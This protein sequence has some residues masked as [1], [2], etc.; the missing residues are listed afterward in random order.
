M[1]KELLE[2]LEAK[3]VLRSK[4]ENAQ[5]MEELNSLKD[6]LNALENKEAL[7]IERSKM[8]QKLAN[9]PAAGNT[10]PVPGKGMEEKPDL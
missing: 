5:N 6:E 4:I 3:K 10:L 2:L 7:I 1:N 8:A 9:N